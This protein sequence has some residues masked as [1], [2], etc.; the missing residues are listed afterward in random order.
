M[1]PTRRRAFTLVELLVVVGIISVLIAILLPALGRAREHARRVKCA[2]NL[3][4][5]GHALTMYTQAYHRYPGLMAEN[6]NDEG[7][8]GIWPVRLRPFLDNGTEVFHCPSQDEDARW[9]SDGPQPVVRCSG[10]IFPVFGYEPG[11]PL[12]HFG[13][14]FSY[15]YNGWGYARVPGKAL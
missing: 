4:A 10:D 7:F 12:I 9:D 13:A 8:V 5:M 14:H 1:P 2:A 6:G 11:E 15:G 3:R